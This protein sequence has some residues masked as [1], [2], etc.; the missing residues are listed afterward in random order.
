MN[1]LKQFLIWWAK[2]STQSI[3]EYWPELRFRAL[4]FF[5]VIS[6]LMLVAS[7]LLTI[8][9]VLS[10]YF[11]KDGAWI[12]YSTLVVWAIMPSLYL[13]SRYFYFKWQEWQQEQARLLETLSRKNYS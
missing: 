3:R 2:D 11:D 10:A 8:I 13:L 12:N 1:N 6:I 9:A 5:D 7:L 4:Q